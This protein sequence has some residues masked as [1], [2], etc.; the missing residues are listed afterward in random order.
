MVMAATTS[1]ILLLSNKK[2]R[3]QDIVEEEFEDEM[4]S[5]EGRVVMVEGDCGE[6]FDFRLSTTEEQPAVLGPC[7]MYTT[8]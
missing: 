2:R 5:W 1:L 6:T 7:Q 8:I 4:G 3:D